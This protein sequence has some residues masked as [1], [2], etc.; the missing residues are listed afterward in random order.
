M[1]NYIL[2]DPRATEI[3][4]VGHQLHL[5]LGADVSQVTAAFQAV[6]ALGPGM[7]NHVT[8]LD[9]SIYADPGECYSVRTIPPCLASYGASPPQQVLSDQVLPYRALFN[10]FN[11]PSVQSVTA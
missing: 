9:V 7:V 6:E 2:A 5:Q 1:A 4:G 10:A 11:R 8:E 3:D